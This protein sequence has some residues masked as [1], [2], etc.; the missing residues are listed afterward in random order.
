M[1]YGFGIND[2]DYVTFPT[3]NGVRVKCKAFQAWQNM[4]ARAYS[5]SYH[6]RYP[7]YIGVTVCD[8]WR[9]FMKFREWWL[10]NHVDGWELDKDLL[11]DGGIYSPKSCIYIPRWLNGFLCGADAARG[12]LPIGVRYEDSR[13]LFRSECSHPITGRKIFIGRFTCQ[14]KAHQAWLSKKI[15][16]ANELKEAMNSIDARI[17]DAVVKKLK[18]KV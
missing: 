14:D 13:G 11:S 18:E 15:S 8:E 3:V 5:K 7:T 17:Y 10:T 16:I 12:G 6:S 4:L 9:S 2:A 1:L